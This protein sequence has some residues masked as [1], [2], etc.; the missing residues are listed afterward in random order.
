VEGTSA[1]HAHEGAPWLGRTPASREAGRAAATGRARDG[2]AMDVTAGR[3][4]RAGA[5]CW[6]RNRTTACRNSRKQ[7]CGTARRGKIRRRSE[8]SNESTV[9]QVAKV[10]DV[11]TNRDRAQLTLGRDVAARSWDVRTGKR[12]AVEA[13]GCC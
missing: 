5:F 13:A 2:A 1:G 8:M 7:R 6:A 11:V 12:D 9:R 10:D 4:G 3:A